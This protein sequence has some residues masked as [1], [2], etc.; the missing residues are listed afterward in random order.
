MRLQKQLSNIIAGK[1]YPKYVIIVPPPAIE[2][3][4]WKRGE[5]LEHEVKDNTLLIRKAESDA[6]AEYE[7]GKI[8]SKYSKRRHKRT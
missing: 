8:V 7:A 5:E 2:Q 6:A 1:E 4:G 3:L